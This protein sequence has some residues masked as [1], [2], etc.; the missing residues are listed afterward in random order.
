MSDTH[1]WTVT[2]C[3]ARVHPLATF[4][5]WCFLG[6]CNQIWVRSRMQSWVVHWKWHLR[7]Q[8]GCTICRIHNFQ[9]MIMSRRLPRW[10]QRCSRP[11]PMAGSASHPVVTCAVCWRCPNP[12]TVFRAR[13]AVPVTAVRRGKVCSDF[14]SKGVRVGDSHCTNSLLAWA[15]GYVQTDAAVVYEWGD[16]QTMY[17]GCVFLIM[18]CAL[19]G[20]ITSLAVSPLLI[21]SEYYTE[22]QSKEKLLTRTNIRWSPSAVFFFV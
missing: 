20:N 1:I 16:F 19:F 5:T 13:V 6:T 3:T 18:Q 7:V 2:P 8:L 15:C 4:Y 11:R 22:N 12:T 9:V 14:F 10:S 21:Y 17:I